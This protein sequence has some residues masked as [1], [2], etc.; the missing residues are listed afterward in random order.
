MRKGLNC[1]T[2]GWPQSQRDP[3]LPLPPKCALPHSDTGVLGTMPGSLLHT[4]HR[5]KYYFISRSLVLKLKPA[6]EILLRAVKTDCLSQQLVI[7]FAGVGVEVGVGGKHVCLTSSQVVL[8]VLICRAH[9]QT[10]FLVT[11]SQAIYCIINI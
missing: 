8:M 10:P 2:P 3:L 4:L 11:E 6:P 7:L 5:T 9:F 1:V